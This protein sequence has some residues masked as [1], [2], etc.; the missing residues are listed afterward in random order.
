[1]VSFDTLPA[2]IILETLQFVR[3][4]DLENF[5]QLSRRTFLLVAPFLVEHRALIRNYHTLRTDTDSGSIKPFL[6]ATLANPRIAS[7]VKKIELGRLVEA[8]AA[9]DSTAESDSVYIEGE[10]EI[11][12]KA[13]LDS[14]CLYRAYGNRVSDQRQYWSDMIQ[15]GDEDILLA[16]LLPLLPNLAALS[17]VAKSTQLDWYDCVINEAAS[18]SK[19]TLCKLTHIR[20]N[21][22]GDEG[23]H[24]DEIQRFCALPSV[25]ELRA[26]KAF[27]VD[28]LYQLIQVASSNVTTLS[29]PHSSIDSNV[30][31]EFLRGFPKLQSFTYSYMDTADGASHDA[32]LIRAGLLAHCKTTLQRWFFLALGP[33]SLP[34][35]GSLRGFEALKKLET[36]WSF[37]V[38]EFPD[39]LNPDSRG[40]QLCWLNEHLPASLMWL[41]IHDIRGRED[42]KKLFLSGR[43]AKGHRLQKLKM[44][45]LVL[46]SRWP[47]EMLTR[48]E[49]LDEG[50]IPAFF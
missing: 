38:P 37:L 21:P 1:M 44:L 6:R 27:G 11:F 2:D 12:T 24:V 18:A 39:P 30:L 33:G 45:I 32:F 14:E 41:K 25:R 20:L 36:Q 49:C 22:R 46:W 3:P 8:T 28:Y 9:S 7:Y 13:A 43:Y 50:P 47:P 16:I 35:M 34:F 40:P 26:P 15:N 48:E 42:S 19:P 4:D 5:A 31:Y 17:V 29:L 10:L 23:F